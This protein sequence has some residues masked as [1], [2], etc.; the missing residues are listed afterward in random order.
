MVIIILSV[1][2]V[3]LETVPSL[4]DKYG[5]FFYVLEWIFT[6]IFTIEYALRLYC[7]YRPWK[8]AKSFFGIKA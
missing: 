6:I 8:Y 1:I 7:V 2:V 4:H 5:N 3:L